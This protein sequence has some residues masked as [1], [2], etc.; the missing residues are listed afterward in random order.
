MDP[1]MTSTPYYIPF[2]RAKSGEIEALAWLSPRTKTRVRPLIDIPKQPEK[3]KRSFAK[4]LC[5]KTAALKSAWGTE[6]PLYLDM[7]R[8][9]PDM[10]VDGSEQP[11]K[12]IFDIARQSRLLAIPVTGTLISRGPEPVYLDAVGAIARRDQRGVAFR[13]SHAEFV[14][15]SR[16]IMTVEAT[17]QLV[18]VNASVCDIILDLEAIDRLPSDAA[19]FDRLF[20][21]CRAAI[22]ALEDRPYRSVTLSGSSIPEIVGKKYNEKPCRVD[23]IEFKVWKALNSEKWRPRIV[24]GDYGI[25]YAFQSDGGAPVQPP[26]RIRLSTETEHVLFRSNPNTYRQLRSRVAHNIATTTQSECW[27]KRAI[28][29]EGHGFTDVGNA[30][31]WVAWDTN[32]HIETTHRHISTELSATRRL[33]R[34]TFRDSESAPWL[35]DNLDISDIRP[36]TR[37]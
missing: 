9:S 2:L 20:S 17:R 27:G 24:F 12:R 11:I 32:A 7:S 28:I 23:R 33:P 1:E 14:D 29:G 31:K 5:D 26:S 25:V 10:L 18:G 16:L 37:P 35:Q 22:V 36:P 4:Y 21:V 8:Y 15:A 3:D 19:T 6:H 34:R 30:T 13:F